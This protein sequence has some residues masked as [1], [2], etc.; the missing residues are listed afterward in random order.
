MKRILVITPTFAPR[1]CGVSHYADTLMKYWPEAN[2]SVVNLVRFGAE[3][4]KAYS[5]R[6]DIYQFSNALSFARLL[7][8]FQD[9]DI[10][11]QYA[12]RGYSRFGCPLWMPVVLENHLR[13][14]PDVKLI[15][16][17]H[18]MWLPLPVFSKYFLPETIGRMTIERVVKLAHGIFVP[19]PGHADV[20]KTRVPSASIAIAPVGSNIVP[21]HAPGPWSARDRGDLVVFGMGFQRFLTAEMFGDYLARWH[22]NGVLQRLHVVGPRDDKW[23]IEEER[24][25]RK[26]LPESALILHGALEPAQISD[27]LFRCG[28]ALSC[29]TRDNLFKSGSFMAF[30][31]HG[32]VIVSK[33]GGE[34]AP[35]SYLVHPD[36]VG[37]VS[38]EALSDK[39][40]NIVQ[41]YNVTIDWA[42][43]ARRM[44]NILSNHKKGTS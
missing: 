21:P 1:P 15:A 38:I 40:V 29:Q 36:Q 4:A 6:D 44:F 41:W 22:Q 33:V 19:T 37:V 3:E 27:L 10:I 2:V 23:S 17:I 39:S 9:A 25:L 35:Y 5:G 20:L 16:V 26:V 43:T 11:L 30:A 18:E 7:R 8:Q 31:S 42:D 28:F 12:A 34:M 13:R 24:I 32:C 14:R